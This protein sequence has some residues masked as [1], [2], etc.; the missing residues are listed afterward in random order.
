MEYIKN[1]QTQDKRYG[2]NISRGGEWHEYSEEAKERLSK[3][4]SGSGNPNYGNYWTEEEKKEWSLKHSGINAPGYG[5]EISDE[6]RA[7]ISASHTG[8][9]RTVEMRN[10]ISNTL[11]EGYATGRIIASHHEC[12]FKGK[13]RPEFSQKMRG[14][15]CSIQISDLNGNIIAIFRGQL[16]I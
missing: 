8:E 10:R 2:Y 6:K 3:Q 1:N 13:K 5:K 16:D 9:I 7:K 12:V 14:K 11:K 15:K 4:F